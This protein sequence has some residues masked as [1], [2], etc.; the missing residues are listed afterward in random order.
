MKGARAK[1]LLLMLAVILWFCVIVVPSI[2][3]LQKTRAEAKNKTVVSMTIGEL[4]HSYRRELSH[5]KYD[6]NQDM[7][8]DLLKKAGE[9]VNTFLRDLSNVSAREQV[10][11]RRFSAANRLDS[12]ILKSLRQLESTFDYIILPRT[13]RGGDSFT[14]Y[15]T[16]RVD[17]T[18]N[19]AVGT[20]SFVMS[21]GFAALCLYLHPAHQSNSKVRYLGHE[22]EPPL[23]HIIAFAQKAESS[24]YLA[25]CDFGARAAESVRFLVQGFVWIDPDSFQILHMR[26]SMLL[27]EKKT[28][29]REQNTDVLYEKVEFDKS[30]QYFWLPREVNVSWEFP[31]W[32]YRSQHKYSDYRLFTVESDYKITPP[33]IN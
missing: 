20:N 21:F 24:D 4:R 19:P 2:P 13:G 28:V 12:P 17:R 15:R 9:K 5:L 22:K 33:K 30:G 8:K 16:N 1:A 14:E 7:L 18:D 23:A 3:A 6:P 32:I 29:L 26:T 11:Q 27:P 10:L 25:Q 31:E